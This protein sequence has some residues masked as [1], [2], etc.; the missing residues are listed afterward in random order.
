MPILKHAIKKKRQ[1]AVRTERNKRVRTQ[2]KSALKKAASGV[3]DDKNLAAAFS[4]LDRAA[5]HNLIHK[6]KADRLKSRLAKKNI[7]Q[8]PKEIVKSPSKTSKA[9][10]KKPAAKK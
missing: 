10:A 9:T 4:A 6:R 3:A 2:M 1:D 7:K 5:K 8:S